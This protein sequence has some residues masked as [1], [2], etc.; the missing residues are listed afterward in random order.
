MRAGLFPATVA[1]VAG[2]S[3]PG[4]TRDVTL[5]AAA[6]ATYDGI[7]DEAVKLVGGR[8][9]GEP[10]AESGASRPQ[11]QLIK[12][13]AVTGDVDGDGNEEAVVALAASF[14]GSGTY[15]FL[16]VVDASDGNVRSVAVEPLGDRPVIRSLG[17]ANGVITAETTE[18]AEGDPMC[19]PTLDRLRRW[20]VGENGL[21]ELAPDGK[22]ARFRGHVVLGHDLRYLEACDTARRTWLIDRTGGDLAD[23]YRRLALEN[24]Q[25]IFFE[26]LATPV[27]APETGPGAD[28]EAS[29][30][31]DAVLRA[32]REGFGCKEPL[33][34][35]LFRAFGNEPSWQMQARSNGLL[36]SALGKDSASFVDYK[37]ERVGK[38][39]RISAVNEET[40][41][42]V[43]ITNER[44]T[45]SMSGSIYAYAA[46]VRIGD[47]SYR[48]CAVE[49]LATA[50][51]RRN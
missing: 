7:L 43:L 30:A 32:E 4:G 36:V 27:P 51:R 22:T 12:E 20:T 3:V 49:G 11:V 33:D 38:S 34:E 45:D 8:F 29:I 44:C 35:F 46:V 18:H 24:D 25:P 31:V 39:V 6:S 26:L 5:E 42:E 28:F 13:L 10:F 37:T 47:A 15:L 19:C 1:L 48:G 50:N 41:L 2:C 9:E 21:D 16:A 23:T 40:S 17:I 14:G